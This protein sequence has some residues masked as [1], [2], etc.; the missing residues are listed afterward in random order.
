MVPP[1]FTSSPT[2]YRPDENSE[3]ECAPITPTT[4]G[5]SFL[6][7][8]SI[9]ADEI[10]GHV[11]NG[12]RVRPLHIDD[13]DKGFLHVL[14]Q[15]TSVGE[16]DRSS[17]E[18]RFR[19]MQ[20]TIPSTY[21]VCVVEELDSTRVVGAATLVLEWKFIHSAGSR[22]RVEDVVVDE[23]MRGKKLGVLLNDVLVRLAKQMGVYKVSLE[24]NDKLIPFYEQFGYKKDAGNN[25]LVQRFDGHSKM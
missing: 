17:W 23:S 8:S 19:S 11:P 16:I 7:D 12:L 13:Y 22:G 2:E 6:F 9:L 10:V 18:W 24:C 20:R 15:L 14:S 3:E 4:K 5:S 25:F 1:V 21:F